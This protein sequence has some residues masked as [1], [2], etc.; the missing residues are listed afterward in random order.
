MKLSDYVAAFER[1]EAV[2]VQRISGDRAWIAKTCNFWDEQQNY[3]MKPKPLECWANV[4]KLDNVH[5]HLTR[6]SAVHHASQ[7]ATRTAVRM[8]EA[9]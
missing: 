5:F 1:G 3:R 6:E 8:I 7:E 2:Q 4:Y 9:P